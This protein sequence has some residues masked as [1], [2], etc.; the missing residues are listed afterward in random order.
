MTSPPRARFA[1]GDFVN[2]NG[3]VREVIGHRARKLILAGAHV[4]QTCAGRPAF[5]AIPASPIG[6]APPR[7]RRLPM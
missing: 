7:A 3:T 5:S 2:H 6:L 1:V 4:G